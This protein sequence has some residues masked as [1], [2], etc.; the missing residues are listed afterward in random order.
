MFRGARIGGCEDECFR[1]VVD[2]VGH[3]DGDGLLSDEL[4]SRVA[5]GGQRLKWGGLAARVGI[6]ARR[7]NVQVSGRRGQSAEQNYGRREL[8]ETGKLP[9]AD[10]DSASSG[11]RSLRLTRTNGSVLCLRTWLVSSLQT[12]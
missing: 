1:Q 8:G 3:M 12:S 10:H 5:R 7:G 6:P 11:E 4:A 2:P 9:S